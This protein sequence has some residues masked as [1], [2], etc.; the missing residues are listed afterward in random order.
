MK[1]TTAFFILIPLFFILNSCIG[2]SINI[3]MNKDGSGKIVME[4]RVSQT[5]QNLGTLDGNEAMPSVPLS[6]DDWK[7]MVDR[8]PGLKLASFSTKKD[9]QDTV[10]SVTLEFKE[11]EALLAFLDPI[12]EKIMLKRLDASGTLEI[13]IISEPEPFLDDDKYMDMIK[14][15]FEGYNFTF[16]FKA[17]GNSV[18]A[19]IDGK[20]NP[21]STPP[22]AE[23]VL[24]G[25]NVT[26]TIPMADLFDIKD[27]LG[28]RFIW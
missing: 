17:P 20:G 12:G 28:V 26:I 8:I 14:M 13:I 10:I 4:Y 7:K 23:A 2:M 24:A 11:E 27:G 5:F 1:K 22:S 6:R 9:K 21:V 18:L 25:K 3:Q 15:L 16:G 19:I